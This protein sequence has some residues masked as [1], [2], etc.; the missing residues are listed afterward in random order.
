MMASTWASRRTTPTPCCS[1]AWAISTS[2]STTTPRRPRACW[3]SRSRS[4]A[5]RP[6]QPVVMCRR[7]LP[8][9]RQLPGAADQAG[10]IG[11]HLRAGRRGRRGQGA[12]G[13]QGGARGHARHA[14]RR[15]AAATTRAESLLLAVHA[16]TRNFCGLAWLSV[17]QAP[18]C[19]WPNAPADALE[20]WIAR[21]A[22]ERAALQRRGHARLRAAPEGRAQRRA[23]HALAAARPGSSTA[24]W[25][26]ASCCEQ[27]GSSSLAAWGAEALANAHAAAAALLGYAEHT[28]GR[29][30]SHVQRLAVRARRRA[31]RAAADHAP[32]PGAGADPARRGLAHAVL[33]AGHLHDRHG[34]PRCSSAGCWRRGAS[35][36]RRRRGSKPSPRCSR[37][38]CGTARLAPARRSRAPATSSASPRAS[39]CA[40]CARASW[41]RCGMALAKAAAA[42]AAPAGARPRCWRESPASLAPPAGCAELLAARASCAEPAALVRDGGVIA[43]GHDAELDELRAISENCDGFL[44]E[45]EARERER[46]GIANL[47]VQ[48]NKRARLLHRGHARR[49]S[50]R[51]RTTTAAARR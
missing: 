22:P 5:S 38:A 27:M 17:T 7:A 28:Q 47:R 21:I 24:A 15:R 14:D 51:C 25:A 36:A 8:L 39:R 40:R 29:A 31:D 34:Q 16:G 30:L 33:A 48:F 26:S 23:L 32:Q 11:G 19:S 6:A 1:T 46:T 37:G 3:T 10:R 9:G 43:T 18:S 41:W 2:C 4:A 35:A 45:L 50:T 44:L 13:A 20:A 42:G 49:S 12:G